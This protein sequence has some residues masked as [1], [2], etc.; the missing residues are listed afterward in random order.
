VVFFQENRRVQKRS[1]L[2][3]MTGSSG[4]LNPHEVTREGEREWTGNPRRPP[5]FL[6]D[7]GRDERESNRG[8]RRPNELQKT[9]REEDSRGE[10]DGTTRMIFER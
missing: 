6:N 4:G 2:T 7:M 9:S 8:G 5:T 3:K 10:K 1:S